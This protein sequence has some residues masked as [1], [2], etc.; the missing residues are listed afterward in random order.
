MFERFPQANVVGIAL[1][2]KMLNELARKDQPWQ[3]HLRLIRGFFL[4]L[5]LGKST[6]DAVI[7]SMALHHWIPGVKLRLYERIRIALRRGGVFVNDDY[8][9]T[10]QEST[11]RLASFK[12]SCISDRHLQHIDLPL[13]IQQEQELPQEAGF[14]AIRLA[15]RRANTCVFAAVT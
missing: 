2:A 12:A 14:P 10:E 7:S 8:V 9:T 15:F 4:E 6:Y 3:A 13:S 5:D 1:S 11:E